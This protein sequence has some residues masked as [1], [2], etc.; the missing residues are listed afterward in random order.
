MAILKKIFQRAYAF[1]Y[2]AG[3]GYT[4]FIKLI[5]TLF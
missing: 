1:K 2:K 3:I 5:G 4:G